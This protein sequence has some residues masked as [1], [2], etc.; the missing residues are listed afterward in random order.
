M[1]V[2]NQYSKIIKIGL[3]G[4]VALALLILATL[5]WFKPIRVV[6]AHHL[7]LLHCEDHICVDDAKTEPLAKT[8]YNR[9]LQETQDKVGAFHQQPTM[10]F[11]STLECANTFGMGKAAAK[12][13]GNL[14]LLVA[15]RGWKDFYITH[16][17]IHHRQAEEWGNI[18][19]L[20][21]PKW[22][23][24]GMAYS[25]SDDPRPTLSEPFQQWRAQFKLWH[26]QNPNPNIWY[27]TGKVK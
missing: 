21:K 7:S 11:C 13:V 19:M 3:Y 16:E 23:V 9:A 25:L 15:P 8:L 6:F 27:T 22:L 14:G 26:Q 18:A 20:T 1:I 4:F 17:L 24:E 10:V 2:N 5:I 12:A